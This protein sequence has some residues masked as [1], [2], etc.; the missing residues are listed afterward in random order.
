MA[1]ISETEHLELRRSP[2]A[3][4]SQNIAA[5]DDDRPH[6]VERRWRVAQYAADRNVNRAA[7]MSSPVLVRRQR[8]HDLR[9]GGEHTQKFAMLDLAHD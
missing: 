3:E 7:D 8:V 1:D 4:V 5:I 2:R 9:A 6:A